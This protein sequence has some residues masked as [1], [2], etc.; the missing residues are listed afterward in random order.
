MGA[1][2]G[3]DSRPSSPFTGMSGGNISGGHSLPQ[4]PDYSGLPSANNP[5]YRPNLNVTPPKIGAN[6]FNR[7][8]AVMSVVSSLYDIYQA[9]QEDKKKPVDVP[10]EASDIA[11]HMVDKGEANKKLNDELDKIKSEASELAPDKNLLQVMSDNTASIVDSIN[12]FTKTY[13]QKMDFLSEYVYG[14]ICYLDIFANNIM[15]AEERAKT[16]ESRSYKEGDTILSPD[17][18]A[19]K[20]DLSVMKYFDKMTSPVPY[21]ILEA[22]NVVG[23]TPQELHASKLSFDVDAHVFNSTA[24][25]ATDLDGNKLT[26]LAPREVAFARQAT[27]LR[28]H[29]DENN[30]SLDDF[31]WGDT[32]YSFDLGSWG[33]IS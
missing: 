3:V 20:K 15:S 22:T 28:M 29:T 6:A 17:E 24:R 8:A 30:F 12:T 33:D 16:K 7:A 11:S 1:W 2:A 23:M 9:S 19:M 13:A 25:T 32:G 27:T 10:Q 26:T 4:I 31:D 21:K 5:R 14:V 18:I